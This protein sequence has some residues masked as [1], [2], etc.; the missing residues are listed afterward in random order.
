MFLKV[1][2][3]KISHCNADFP[4]LKSFL[5]F[6]PTLTQVFQ[7]SIMWTARLNTVL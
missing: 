7:K 1:Y 4:S 5:K 6:F 2:I 3:L